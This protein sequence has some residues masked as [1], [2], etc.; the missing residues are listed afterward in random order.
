[1]VWTRRGFLVA[2]SGA[3][4]GARGVLSASG[5]GLDQFSASGAACNDAGKTTPAVPRDATFKSGSP[6]RASLVETGSP[7]LVL[8]GTVSGLT[9]GR[10]KDARVDFWHTDPAG[11]YDMQGYRRG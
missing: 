4:L 9:C 10:I 1:M 5:Q 11:V 7:T 2:G 8:S 6:R 3:F